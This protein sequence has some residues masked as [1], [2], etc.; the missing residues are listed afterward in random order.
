MVRERNALWRVKSEELEQT[1]EVE[2]AHGAQ[3]LLVVERARA[4][5][6]RVFALLK[7]LSAAARRWYVVVTAQ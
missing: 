6:F 3:L 5:S 1:L 2:H 7:E 4:M